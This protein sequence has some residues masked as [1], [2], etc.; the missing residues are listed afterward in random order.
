MLA[1]ESPRSSHGA[2]DAAKFQDNPRD[3]NLALGCGPYAAGCLHRY[4]FTA[5]E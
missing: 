3:E 5:V 2:N 1:I 4:F